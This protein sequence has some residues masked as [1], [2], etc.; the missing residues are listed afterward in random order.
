MVEKLKIG[1]RIIVSLPVIVLLVI[2]VIAVGLPFLIG[3][4][5]SMGVYV[6]SKNTIG[7]LS[8]KV[9]ANPFFEL[10]SLSIFV[11][12]YAIGLLFYVPLAIASI[13]LI[14]YFHI[15]EYLAGR[16]LNKHG[17]ALQNS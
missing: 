8:P 14:I 7:K 13:P 11:P 15:S 4:L 9:Q 17:F 2:I 16:W 12:L 3:Y 1:L 5:I 6:L 10:L